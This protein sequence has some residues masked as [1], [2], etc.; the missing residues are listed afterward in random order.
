MWF[1]V[2]SIVSRETILSVTQKKKQKILHRTAISTAVRI[3]L[4]WGYSSNPKSIWKPELEATMDIAA[5]FVI[6]AVGGVLEL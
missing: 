4:P 2:M 1:I 5:T 6:G 3:L